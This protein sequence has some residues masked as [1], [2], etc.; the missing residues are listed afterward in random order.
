M[1]RIWL[2]LWVALRLT[3][4]GA[5]QDLPPPEHR[6]PILIQACWAGAAGGKVHLVTQPSN[7]ALPLLAQPGAIVTNTA[8]PPCA[9]FGLWVAND[10]KARRVAE[11]A[12]PKTGQRFIL[13]LQ[14]EH[15]A[16]MRAWLV[17]ADLETFPWGS[18]CLL[19]LSDKRLRC[20][21]NGME[22]T[23]D[24]GQSGVVPLVATERVSAHLAL[25]YLDGKK[26]LPD[27]STK[28]IL[29]P[30]KR[31]ILVVGPGLAAQGPLPKETVVETNPVPVTAPTPLPH[32]PTK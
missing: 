7:Q 20:Q 21:L 31:F 13:V 24:P 11:F 6:G 12:F 4:Q 9:G 18:A 5:S 26:W 17:P 16:S 29:T 27:C 28:T 8:V 10:P 23:V 14:G 1:K 25:D 3:A 2:G 22:A 15:P 30:S 32:P 19:N